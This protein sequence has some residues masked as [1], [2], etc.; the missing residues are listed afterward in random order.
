M[1]KEKLK[2]IM[3]EGYKDKLMILYSYLE[4]KGFDNNKETRHEVNGMIFGLVLGT[5]T[6]LVKNDVLE[7][8]SGWEE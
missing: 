1:D 2:K 6:G 4:Q 7:F 3:A 5:I 8:K